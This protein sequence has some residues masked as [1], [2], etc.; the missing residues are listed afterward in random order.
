MPSPL[1]VDDLMFW[2]NDGGMVFCLEANTGRRHCMPRG[3]STLLA[4]KEKCR[5]FQR[6]ENINCLPKTRQDA[7]RD[8][9]GDAQLEDIQL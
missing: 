6:R 5:L 4:K 8:Q 7:G 2:I 3:R 9:K 1:I